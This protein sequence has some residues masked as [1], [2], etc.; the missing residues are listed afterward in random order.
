MK[1]IFCTF[2]IFTSNAFAQNTT[3][4]AKPASAA[5]LQQPTSK[6]APESDAKKLAEA[7]ELSNLLKINKLIQQGMTSVDYVLNAIP[8]EKDKNA[9]EKIK[10]IYATVRLK[11]NLKKDKISEEIQ[12][13]FI[14]ELMKRFSTAEIKYLIEI[15]KYPLFQRYAKFLESEDYYKILS[16]HMTAA[17]DILAEEKKLNSVPSKNLIAPT[18]QKPETK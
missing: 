17:Q 12:E 7:K 14:A 8:I 15:N 2:I 13:Q 3:P 6:N 1:L 9:A 11:Y 4:V 16:R 5:L 18:P 10:I